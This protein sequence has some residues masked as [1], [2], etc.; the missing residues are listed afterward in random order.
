MPVLNDQQTNSRS[1][2]SERRNEIWRISLTNLSPD[3]RELFDDIE[4]A[5]KS[6]LSGGKQQL[7]KKYAD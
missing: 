2:F 5:E 7:R 1:L 6:N 3:S 4:E